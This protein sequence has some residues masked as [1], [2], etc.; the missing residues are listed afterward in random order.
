LYS[1]KKYK[2]VTSYNIGVERKRTATA[3]GLYDS[4]CH[5]FFFF[6]HSFS[7][8][9]FVSQK[10]LNDEKRGGNCLIVPER[11]YGPA[12]CQKWDSNARPFVVGLLVDGSVHSLCNLASRRAL[13][14]TDA[15]SSA[16]SDTPMPLNNGS[17]F[18]FSNCL[19]LSMDQ[20]SWVT[21][22]D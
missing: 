13:F 16:S 22:C 17:R 21:S 3:T 7:L 20:R 14:I 1:L 15:T 18:T 9:S 10:R 4:F 6:L 19:M 11:S 12:W 2:Y 5:I 8:H